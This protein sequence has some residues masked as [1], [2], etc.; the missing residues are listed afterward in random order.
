[1]VGQLLRGEQQHRVLD[2]RELSHLAIDERGN[3]RIQGL[4]V[5]DG[6]AQPSRRSRSAFVEPGT[7]ARCSSISATPLLLKPLVDAWRANSQAR[8]REDLLLMPAP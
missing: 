7:W 6:A 5:G 3:L 1:M 4:T 2:R 8:R